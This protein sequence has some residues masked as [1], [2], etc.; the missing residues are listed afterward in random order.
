[1]TKDVK[2]GAMDNSYMLNDN[3]LFIIQNKK[4]EMLR[5]INSTMLDLYWGIGDLIN[6]HL[7]VKDER[8]VLRHVAIELSKKFG[9][10]TNEAQLNMMRLFALSFDI[11]KSGE[12]MS[13][14]PQAFLPIL[15]EIKDQNQWIYYTRLIH[16]KGLNPQ[17]LI[18]KIEGHDYEKKG[19]NAKYL[20]NPFSDLT[21]KHFKGKT[22]FME[23]YFT[24]QYAS[25]FRALLE[26]TKYKINCASTLNHETSQLIKALD[27]KLMKF[28][29]K[30]NSFLNATLNLC[31]YEVGNL[32]DGYIL[33]DQSQKDSLIKKAAAELQSQHGSLF[34]EKQLLKAIE[35]FRTYKKPFEANDLCSYFFWD[36][37]KDGTSISLFN[38]NHPINIYENSTFLKFIK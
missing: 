12:I 17:Q 30:L 2:I 23:N 7:I 6:N 22:L 25:E 31:F 26:P 35:F 19:L 1:M 10:Y 33:L 20:K 15:V 18:L 16:T 3:A 24:N 14:I 21:K 13:F 37:I 27:V 28:Q 11:S 32:I 5:T 4:W 34:D 9:Y 36:Q 8:V 29:V 38:N